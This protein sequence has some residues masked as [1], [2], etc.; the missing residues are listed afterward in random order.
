[1]LLTARQ[2]VKG[3]SPEW[4]HVRHEGNREWKEVEKKRALDRVKQCFASMQFFLSSIQFLSTLLPIRPCP[5]IH[6]P[7]DR[8]DCSRL[9]SKVSNN[10]ITGEG[11]LSLSLSPT[12]G[13]RAFFFILV[14]IQVGVMNE[15]IWQDFLLVLFDAT[16]SPVPLSIPIVP[17]GRLHNV[18]KPNVISSMKSISTSAVGP[19]HNM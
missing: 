14:V 17:C 19:K 4:R 1:V 18:Y 7:C 3:Y 8:D 2:S 9:T 16:L 13:K 6:A 15:K 12:D 5:H 10:R 11:V